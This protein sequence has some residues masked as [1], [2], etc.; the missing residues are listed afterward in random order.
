MTKSLIASR[1]SSY[2]PFESLAY[3]HLARIGIRHVEILVPTPDN[4]D[5]TCTEL[6]R[7]GLIASSL[8]GECEVSR[9]DIATQIANQ[10]PAFQR[11]GARFMFVSVKAGDIPRSTV[12]QRLREAGDVAADQGVTIVLETHP[13]LITN[14]EIARQTMEAVN[15]P[16]VRVN[17]DTANVYF[18]N[19]DVNAVD[20]LRRVVDFVAS[21]HLKDTDGGFESWHFPALGRGVVD[22]GTIFELLDD[23][24]FSGPCTLEIEG[25]E[26]ETKTRQLVCDRIAESLAYLRKLGRV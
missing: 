5:K 22:F 8:H 16:H 18:Y 11:L 24:G 19:H 13:D 15:H 12:Y 3:E 10:M 21:I 9:S 7:Y 14:G 20:E 17:F 6:E 25:L 4:L 2:A 1:T 23:A 26:G